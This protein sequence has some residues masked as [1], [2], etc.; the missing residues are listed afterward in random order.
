MRWGVNAQKVCIA[1][2]LH[3]CGKLNHLIKY[4]KNKDFEGI[5]RELGILFDKDDRKTPPIW[6]AFASASVARKIFKISDKDI[7]TAIKIHPTGDI[8]MSPV[9]IILFVADFIEPNRRFEGVEKFRKLSFENLSE[10]FKNILE[11]KINYVIKDKKH[12]HPRSKMAMEYY[13]E[14]GVNIH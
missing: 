6:H 8:N 5:E 13:K 1:G 14:K 11:I 10:S 7:I 9:A 4:K 12:L 2:L 3:D